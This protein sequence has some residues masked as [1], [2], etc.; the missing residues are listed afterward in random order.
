MG[1]NNNV[2]GDYGTALGFGLNVSQT[3]AI[4]VGKYNQPMTSG[5]VFAVGVGTITTP[6]TALIVREDGAVIL[7]RAQGDVSMGEYE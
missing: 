6:S 4:A 5:D 2:S 1:Y 3:R 7:G